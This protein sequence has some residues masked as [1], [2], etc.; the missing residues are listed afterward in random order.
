MCLCTLPFHNEKQDKV[1]TLSSSSSNTVLFIDQ[2]LFG[3]GLSFF[4]LKILNRISSDTAVQSSLRFLSLLLLHYSG[5]SCIAAQGEKVW[6]AMGKQ[7]SKHTNL[8]S[9]ICWA[10][11]DQTDHHEWCR[12]LS[13]I[14]MIIFEKLPKNGEKR[15]KKRKVEVN[16]KPTRWL[17]PVQLFCSKNKHSVSMANN[18]RLP[19]PTPAMECCCYLISQCRLSEN[20]ISSFSFPYDQTTTSSSNGNVRDRTDLQPPPLQTRP[21]LIKS[22]RRKT[23]GMAS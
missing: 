20:M 8:Y 5:Q 19:P 3:F 14:I 12:T 22:N 18:W 10:W 15:K 23:S 6:W 7:A 1:Q 13:T 17:L 2:R 16:L 11:M 21:G 9:H 4:V